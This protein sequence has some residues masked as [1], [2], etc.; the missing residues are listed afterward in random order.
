MKN[1][2]KIDLFNF[3]LEIGKQKAYLALSYQVFGPPIGHAPIVVVNHSLTGNS[4]VSGES[5]WWNGIVGK[6]KSIDTD[7]FTVI[8]F[9]IPGNGYDNQ[10]ENL[11]DN[12]RDFTVRDIARIF[13]E[14]LF[15][16]KIE[17]V[18]TVIGGSLG[19]AIAW[20]MTVLQPE[21]I[22]NLIPIATDWK[23]TDWVI[24]N[25]LIQ[26]QIL[27][28]S[29][30]PIVDAR[31]HATL[32]YR[33]PEYVNQRFQ[34]NKLDSSSILQ[35]ENWLLDHGIQLKNRYR[36]AA[37]KLMN[38]LLKTNDITRNR[39]DFLAVAKTIQSH[40]HLIT[41]DSDCLFIAEESRKTYHGLK[42]IKPDVFYHQ[43]QSIHGHDAFLI[44]FNQLSDILKPIFLNHKTQNYVSAQN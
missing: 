4:A 1:I 26:D 5:G 34:R 28:N 36:L 19:G 30:D 7:Y 2:E 25:V 33:T 44:E 32:L 14:G 22:E 23:A 16:L 13:W 18:F 10:A 42:N 39:K 20:E 11:I 29:D 8:V 38:H 35:I 12:Y 21:R 6:N 40:I 17:T 24:A 9:N 41:I 31:L 15:Y 43:I 37:Y 3:D 27:N